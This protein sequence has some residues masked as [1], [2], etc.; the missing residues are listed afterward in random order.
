MKVCVCCIFFLRDADCNAH[1]AKSLFGL[2]FFLFF[3]LIEI[4]ILHDFQDFAGEPA[5]GISRC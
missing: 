5:S 3:F 4:E 1:A 2:F